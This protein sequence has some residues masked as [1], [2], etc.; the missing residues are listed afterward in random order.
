[1]RFIP[2]YL[3]LAAVFT[4]TA[5]Q[6]RAATLEVRLNLIHI[7]AFVKVEIQARTDTPEGIKG[8]QFDILS[9]NN[10]GGVGATPVSAGPPG[11][12][13][14]NTWGSG[15]NGFSKIEP[16]LLDATFQYAGSVPAYPFDPD[17]DLDALGGSFYDPNNFNNTTLGIGGFSTI[18]TQEWLLPNANLANPFPLDLYIIGAQYYDFTNGHEP[19]YAFNYLPENMI[20]NGVRAPEPS[21][22]T[23]ASL[24]L[25]AFG[26]YIRRRKYACNTNPH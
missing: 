12:K 16:S 14:K 1:M 4:C 8:F 3:A 7:H 13:V 11:T 19:N 23:L 21:A 18:A 25:P 2:C 24:L 20:I 26:Y 10:A 6:V 22:L 17:S 5:T 9:A 15:M